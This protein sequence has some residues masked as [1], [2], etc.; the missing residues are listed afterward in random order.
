MEDAHIARPGVVSNSVDGVPISLFGVF[1]GHGGKEVS[2][3]VKLKYTEVLTNLQSFKEGRYRDAL[4]ESFHKID[5]LLEDEQ[6]ASLLKQLRAVPNPSDLRNGK[7]NVPLT[8]DA[9]NAASASAV[10]NKEVSSIIRPL[11]APDRTASPDSDDGMG[12]QSP[13]SHGKKGEVDSMAIIK[14]LLEGAKQYSRAKSRNDSEGI[15]AAATAVTNNL[16]TLKASRAA[17]DASAN[18][19][20]SMEETDK[21]GA[22]VVGTTPSA[23]VD[24]DM[25][26][27][28]KS[29]VTENSENKPAI[30]RESED[31]EFV[32]SHVERDPSQ[33]P[34]PAHLHETNTSVTTVSGKPSSVVIPDQSNTNQSEQKPSP[35]KSP[36]KVNNNPFKG[37]T[38][39][40]VFSERVNE[41]VVN[42]LAEDEPDTEATPLSPAVP[43]SL[44]STEDM[45]NFAEECADKDSNRA[46]LEEDSSDEELSPPKAANRL[47]EE[48]IVAAGL[49]TA[50]EGT[51]SITADTTVAVT[52]LPPAPPNFTTYRK[53]GNTN[54]C[55]LKNHRVLAGCTAIVALLIGDKYLVVANAGDSRGVL[56]R[57]GTAV[58]LSED[59][60]PSQKREITRIKNAGGFVTAVGRV[61]GNLNLSRSLG[62]LK[63]KQVKHLPPEAQMITAEPDIEIFEINPEEDEFFI[64]ACDGIWDVLSNQDACDFVRQKVLQENMSLEEV[65]QA[66][67]KRCLAKDPVSSQGIGGD[68]MTF[69]VVWLQPRTMPL[70]SRPNTARS[71]AES[72]TTSGGGNE[73]DYLAEAI[74][75]ENAVL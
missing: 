6:Y 24:D 46:W 34:A 64:L 22:M 16:R 63:Y 73:S 71:E 44:K 58:A 75:R 61:N 54:I 15:A 14:Q 47:D 1:D 62:D 29:M 68:N 42:G 10:N 30:D 67:M 45:K 35:P 49:S 13:I 17:A 69:M 21:D 5:E 43:P 20:Q 28:S 37:E 8:S 11:T 59:H 56:C 32:S 18:Q 19:H 72:S 52:D 57:N 55:E 40:T 9:L 50:D 60:K 3:F 66:V 48:D 36:S 39:Q 70:V 12:Q 25:E 51:S 38:Y 27:T 53:S 7:T 4:R 26:P 33:S 41:E 2:A 23:F 74:T 65:V 31:P